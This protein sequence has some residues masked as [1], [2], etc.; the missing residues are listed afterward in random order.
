MNRNADDHSIRFVR[1]RQHSG[2]SLK[3]LLMLGLLS[4]SS[5]RAGNKVSVDLQ[6]LSPT[7]SADV[8][9]QFTQ[10]PSPN[11]L[12]AVNHAG[13]VLKK[14]FDRIHGALFT[15]KAGQLK[16][17][18]SNPDITFISPDRK[19]SGSLEFAEPTVNA[20]IAFQSGWTGAGVGVAI[21]NSGIY[22]H[23]DLKGRIVYSES[24]VS[25]DSTTN[26]AYGHGTHVAGIV[27]G[28][29]FDSTGP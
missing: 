29:A 6:G 8:I 18:A 22:Y 9:I 15:I 3:F 17:L 4:A 19:I 2:T 26:D 12:S 16:G 13:G 11:D 1:G 14:K 7:D 21:I 24:F 23:P 5:A 10:S 27:A 28:N 25:G 20:N